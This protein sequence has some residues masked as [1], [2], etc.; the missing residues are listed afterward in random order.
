MTDRPPKP[1][2]NNAPGLKW[3]PRK[4]GWEARW[5]ARLGGK[6]LPLLPAP[7]KTQ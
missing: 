7:T 6:I 5:R 3:L 1:E 2:I 4:C